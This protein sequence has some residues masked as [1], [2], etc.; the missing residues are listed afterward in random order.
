MFWKG[1]SVQ[2]IVDIVSCGTE[3]PC[4]YLDSET[5]QNL[6]KRQIGKDSQQS[7]NWH[8]KSFII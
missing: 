2:D 3:L 7:L 5:L 8:Q 1:R 4:I 6:S